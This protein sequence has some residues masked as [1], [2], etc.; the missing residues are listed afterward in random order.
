MLNNFPELK[1]QS[2]LWLLAEA[3]QPATR[4]GPAT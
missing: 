2:I 4:G 1:V 3:N